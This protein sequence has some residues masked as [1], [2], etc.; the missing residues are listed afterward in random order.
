M[1]VPQ[2]NRAR[3]SEDFM[4]KRSS[5][6]SFLARGDLIWSKG[7]KCCA[8][9]F[10]GSENGLVPGMV[11]MRV[12]NELMQTIPPSLSSIQV[13]LFGVRFRCRTG[14]YYRKSPV[15]LLHGGAFFR[16]LARVMNAQSRPR[17]NLGSARTRRRDMRKSMKS[18]R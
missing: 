2:I 11:E 16:G 4:R 7:Q 10:H 12:E 15:Y 1:R 17:R 9:F 6:V 3:Q 13:E 18:I 14:G 8:L 5:R